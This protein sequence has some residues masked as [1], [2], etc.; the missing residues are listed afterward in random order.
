MKC[1]S[2]EN[3]HIKIRLKIESSTG[4]RRSKRGWN[5]ASGKEERNKCARMHVPFNFSGCIIITKYDDDGC[6]GET[7]IPKYLSLEVFLLKKV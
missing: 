6:P 7:D 3:E 5:Q 4:R 1:Y 2:G